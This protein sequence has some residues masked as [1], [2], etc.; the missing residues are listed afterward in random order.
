MR[1]ALIS[2][3]R[4]GWELENSIA[5]RISQYEKHIV[6]MR[7]VKCS[8]LGEISEKREISN[9]L[10]EWLNEV[11]GVVFI[12]A[13]GI[14]VRLIAPFVNSKVFDP[15]IVVLDESG[16]FCVSLLS[17]HIGGANE[18]AWDIA[19]V[20]GAI[21]VI[22][23]ATD[24][25]KRFSVDV[26]AKKNNLHI[27]DM[28]TAKDISAEIVDGKKVGMFS[29]FDIKGSIPKEVETDLSSNRFKVG[30]AVSIKNKISVFDKTL[31][32]CP[33]V[34]TVGVGCKR[35]ISEEKIERAIMT[36]LDDM[37]ISINAVE[38]VSSIDIK[39]NEE[40]ILNFCK[41]YGLVFLTYSSDE[42]S[43]V[44]GDFNE[45]DFVKETTGVG[46]VCER[47]AVFCSKGKLIMD[48]RVFDGVT[49]A[50][51]LKDWSVCFED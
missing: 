40:G 29:E 1:L 28:K 48:K 45:S 10:G 11:D 38:A 35:G 7:E 20:I 42:L 47:S 30:F 16:R 15:A 39:K 12:G 50:L 22:T 17:G 23:T 13:C 51:A 36:C 31:M 9:C 8:A 34:I 2:F 26:F 33:H 24:I 21:P 27:S 32:L 41:K 43:S 4:K 19:A 3:S 5:D 18:L 37:N 25:E 14:A 49:V 44:E 46:S 6:V